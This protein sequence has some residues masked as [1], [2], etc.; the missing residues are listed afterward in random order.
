MTATADIVVGLGWGDEG[1]GA[2]TDFLAYHTSA[3]RVVRFNGGQ[4]AAHN[5]VVGGKH[6]TFASY[7]SGTLSGIPTWISKF[8][9][10]DPLAA[11]SE[12]GVLSWKVPDSYLNI[13][14][15]EECKVTTS[16]HVAVNHRT[17]ISRGDNR[18][19]STGTGFGETVAWEYNGNDPLRVKHLKDPK[20]V[21]EYLRAYHY[22]HDLEDMVRLEDLP[23]IAERLSKTLF[24]GTWGFVRPVSED[25]FLSELSY[26][27]TIFE[28]AQG[29][30]LDET[31]GS[32]PHTTWSTTTPKNARLLAMEAGIDEVVTWGV[33][34]S[35]AT[36]HGHGPFP[37]EGEI[38]VEE[39]HNGTT[40]WAGEFRT[41]AWDLN[42][43]KWAIE[44]T[45]VDKL[46]IT[47]ADQFPGFITTE[48]TIPFK[49]LGEVGI[50][51][52]G[53][54]RE[55]RFFKDPSRI[56]SIT[57]PVVAL[58]RS[59]YLATLMEEERKSLTSSKD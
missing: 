30:M 8:C 47:W 31:F 26:G 56:K 36:R 41:G 24:D 45:G 38:W 35:Y 22:H 13:Y 33:A 16:L 20:I 7:G 1:K 51:S 46:S 2:T 15:H 14:V 23:S 49:D 34:R 3:D 18:H 59:T 25:E 54:D 10:F 5:V 17:E 37:G 55:D 6:H 40:E 53:P 58:R 52:F 4:Q 57:T 39:P 48:G 21:E 50:I 29:F 27:H 32:H 12:L 43:L 42:L 44:T 9:T 28:G 19:G 11:G